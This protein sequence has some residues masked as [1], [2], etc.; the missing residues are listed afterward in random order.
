[1]PA[2][3]ERPRA[4][5]SARDKFP[6]GYVLILPIVLYEG[7]FLLYPMYRGLELGLEQPHGG[8]RARELQP[9]DQRPELFWDTDQA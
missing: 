4:R 2:D 3:V 1:M 5:R 7:I 9:A 6:F 8:H